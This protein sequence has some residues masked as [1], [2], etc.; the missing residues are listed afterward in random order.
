MKGTSTR[1]SSLIPFYFHLLMSLYR[2]YRPQTFDD[3]VGQEHIA[4]TL[5]NALSSTP[6]RVAH[7][8]LFVG[9][10]GTGKTT[11]ARL[12]AKALNCENGPTPTP[13][14]ECDFCVRVRDNQP[15]MDLIEIDAASNRGIDNVRDLISGVASTPAQSRYRVYIIDEVHML[16][17]ESFNALLKTLEEPPPHAIF[18]LA[19]TDAHKVPT[20][21]SSRCQRFD[22]RR[23]GPNDIVGRLQYV[24]NLENIKLSDGAAQLIAQQADGALRDSLTLLEQVTAFSAEEISEDDVRLVL[25][26]VSRELLLDM[27][28][29]V[30][31]RD[32]S[33]A[34]HLVERATEDG[35]SF[36]QLTRDLT[37]YSRDLL[38]L[39]VGFEGNAA[40][41]ADER[42]R[43]Q[44]HAQI[45]GRERITHAVET[46]RASEKEMRQST[47][48]RLLLELAL[49]RLCSNIEY[50]NAQ[51]ASQQ[52][53]SQRPQAA[54]QTPQLNAQSAS[55]QNATR[56]I[57]RQPT[58]AQTSTSNTTTAAQPQAQAPFSQSTSPQPQPTQSQSPQ[59]STPRENV[60]LTAPQVSSIESEQSPSEQSPSG[61]AKGEQLRNE[62]SQ[63]EASPT[64]ASPVEELP[65]ARVVVANDESS[66]RFSNQAAPPE[67]ESGYDEMVAPQN[68]DISENA[69]RENIAAQSDSSEEPREDLSMEIAAKNAVIEA[70]TDVATTRKKGRRIHDLEEFTELW[71]AI[72]MRV[73]R[74]IGVTAVAYLHDGLPAALDDKEAIVE[75]Q[76]EFHYEKACEAARRLPFEQVLNECMATPHRLKFRLA[77]KKKAAPKIEEDVPPPSED[78]DDEEDVVRMAQDIF[79]AEVVGRSG[80]G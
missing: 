56:P 57:W 75:F 55:A 59:V 31:N 8:Y 50:S 20:T 10:R 48:H 4:Q 70:P 34:L 28:E 71:P 52:P 43:R 23:V 47:D 38:L 26:T 51:A 30:A 74:K 5:R 16:T 44:N 63:A 41:S 77:S 61:Q 11:S 21:I 6:L 65:A 73:K 24:A 60:E 7:A 69:L 49:V 67:A 2:K 12:L 46:L 68:A 22:F 45:L 80:E 53:N 72:L 42:A 58:V 39:S 33:S 25:G 79:G 19:T 32:A 76:K 35:V 15:T 54:L 13:C 17:T 66:T 14:N 36:S 37:G 29:A 78:D 62:A 40:H 3:L 64:E 9:P 18:I 1:F 27:M